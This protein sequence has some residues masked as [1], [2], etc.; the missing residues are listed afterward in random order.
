MRIFCPAMVAARSFVLVSAGQRLALRS[1]RSGVSRRWTQTG[2]QESSCA[3]GLVCGPPKVA[4]RLADHPQPLAGT[5]AEGADF[6]ISSSHVEQPIKF[7][8]GAIK[9]DYQG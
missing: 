9:S 5:I 4:Q 2:A 3:G 1:T 8:N 6:A 7:Y